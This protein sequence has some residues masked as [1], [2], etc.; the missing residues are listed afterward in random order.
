MSVG[1]DIEEIN[2]IR[3]NDLMIETLTASEE[4]FV[5]VWITQHE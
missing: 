4:A 2:R 1:I 3:N 5:R